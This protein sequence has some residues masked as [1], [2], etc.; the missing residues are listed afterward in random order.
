MIYNAKYEAINRTELEQLQIERL[1]LTLNRVYRNVKFYKNKFN[2]YNVNIEN[3]NSVNDIKNLPFTTHD[4]LR[5]AYPYDMFAV[6]LR[7]IV[8]IHTTSGTTGKPVVVGYT[9][10]DLHNWS[11]VVARTLIS[12]GVTNQDIVQ[13]AFNYGLFTGGF[14]FHYGAERIGASVIPASASDNFQKQLTI[15]R[16]FKTTVILST[17]GYIL[18]I[19]QAVAESGIHAEQLFLKTGLFG[20]EPWSLSLRS[21]IE[22][23]LRIKAYDTYGLSEIIGPGVAAECE[24][25]CGL[26]INEDHFIV[27]VIDPKTMNPVKPG[28]PGELVFTTITKEGF[29]LIR[30]RTGDIS[31]VNNVSCTCGRTLARMTRVSGRTDDMIFFNSTKFFPS[32][33]E[34]VIL[35]AEGVE[36]N[37]QII[38]DNKD[39]ADTIEVKIE[40]SDKLPAFDEIKGLEL[41]KTNIVKSLETELGIMKP[42]ITLVEPKSLKF[43]ADNKTVRVVDNRKK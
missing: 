25:K 37:Y 4:D 10:N 19:I 11:E 34:K 38:L 20:A 39:G 3:I 1:Q 26:H 35:T 5:N 12:A 41:L 21:Y 36:P 42:R 9:K 13:I 8:R 33:I 28:D 30:Y 16:D 43:V 22:E 23:K 17:P 14:G 6:P 2:E 7:D 27:E 18:S 15:M 31:S 29:P 40:I 32:Q 24:Y